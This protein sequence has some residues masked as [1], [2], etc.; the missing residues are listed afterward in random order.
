MHLISQ[1]ELEVQ[2]KRFGNFLFLFTQL[3]MGEA[4]VGIL[5]PDVTHRG[6]AGDASEYVIILN[7]FQKVT[8]KR[9]KK[10]YFSL[11]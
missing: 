4:S 8:D 1:Q 2:K 7:L 6:P 9:E 5:N 10:K 3:P 11:E